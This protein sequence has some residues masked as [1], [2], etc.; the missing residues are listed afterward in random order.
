MNKIVSRLFIL[1]SINIYSQKQN[2]WVLG[3]GINYIDFF[4]TNEPS[5]LTGNEVGLFN[6]IANSRD[7]WNIYV[8]MI[9]V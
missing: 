4:P 5:E 3:I 6:E 1:I 8:P 7:H 9:T 2:D